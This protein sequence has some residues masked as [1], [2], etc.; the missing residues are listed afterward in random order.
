M[1]E[2]LV[3]AGDAEAQFTE[4]KSK[5]IAHIF[6][7]ETEA[8]ARAKI[9]EMKKRYWDATHNVYAYVLRSGE[10]RFSDDGEPS[11]T[12]GMPTLDVLR[13]NGVVNVLCVTTRYFGGILLGA[14]GLTRA[15][16]RSA[17]LGIYTAGIAGMTPYARLRIVCH[18]SYLENI[19]RQ[20]QFFDVNETDAAYGAAVELTC[21]LPMTREKDFSARIFDM[22]A[23]N[24]MPRVTEEIFRPVR[25]G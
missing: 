9:A 24:V 14:G 16:G 15:Y 19:R 7:V 5:F 25:R 8:E 18:Y 3:P 10:A 13:K 17:S 4:K 20:F 23:G 2:Y 12:A 22:T 6:A 21:E 1:N 11:G